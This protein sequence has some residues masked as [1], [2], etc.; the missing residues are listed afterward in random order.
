MGSVALLAGSWLTVRLLQALRVRKANCKK[1]RVYSFILRKSPTLKLTCSMLAVFKTILFFR[2]SQ[3]SR[4]PCSNTHSILR[5]LHLSHQMILEWTERSST[6]GCLVIA[7]MI[8]WLSD[9][10]TRQIWWN[11]NSWWDWSLRLTGLRMPQDLLRNHHLL[12]LIRSNAR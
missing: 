4:R 12:S 1:S 3:G 6:T 2:L 10:N 8:R 11:L 9:K 7:I 5:W